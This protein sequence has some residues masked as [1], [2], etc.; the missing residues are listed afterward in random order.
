MCLRDSGRADRYEDPITMP[1]N[2]ICMHLCASATALVRAAT[3]GQ[4]QIG[5]VSPGRVTGRLFC[6]IRKLGEIA[7]PRT[8]AGSLSAV[9]GMLRRRMLVGT[10]ADERR[11]I[12]DTAT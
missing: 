10:T 1:L 8:R 5:N 3:P 9:S 4:M 6:A 2:P 11:S 12:F 7:R